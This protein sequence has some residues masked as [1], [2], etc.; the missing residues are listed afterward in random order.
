MNLKKLEQ[1]SKI[2]LLYMKL[3]GLMKTLEKGHE[4]IQK[5]CKKLKEET[6][7]PAK[8][9]AQELIKKAQAEAE[10]IIAEAEKKAAGYLE[11]AKKKVEKER[12]VFH[13]SLEQASKQSVEALRQEIEKKLFNEQLSDFIKEGT[14]KADVVANL[15]DAIV[16]ALKK[17]GLASDLSAVVPESV[18]ASDVAEKLGETTFKSLQ[19]DKISLGHFAGGAQIRLHGKNITVDIT[20]SALAELLASYVRKDFRSLLFKQS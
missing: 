15:I 20:D 18:K 4:K 12:S 2:L 5:I 1:S 11:A 17:D 16:S 19:K 14:A 3:G 10:Q 6:L 13:S 8:Q 9:E 7:D